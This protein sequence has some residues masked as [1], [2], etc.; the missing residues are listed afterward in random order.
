MSVADFCGVHTATACRIVKRVT[1]SIAELCP[2]F[3]K[4]PE[5]A[6][7]MLT[8]QR[9]FFDIAAFPRVLGVIDCTHVRIQS[10]GEL[11][12]RNFMLIITLYFALL[13]H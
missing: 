10:P 11:M 3:I 1:Q 7:D 8:L 4:F 9:S 5:T 12:C 13:K 6:E 2:Q